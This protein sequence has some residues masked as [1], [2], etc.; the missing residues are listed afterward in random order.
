MSK[1][2]IMIWALVL[3]AVVF[4]ASLF[5]L[6]P[7]PEERL[8]LAVWAGNTVKVKALLEK[9]LDREYGKYR[10]AFRQ[11]LLYRSPGIVQAFVDAESENREEWVLLKAADAGRPE[12]VRLLIEAGWGINGANEKGETPLFIAASHISSQHGETVRF[13]VERGADVNA[14]TEYGCTPYTAFMGALDFTEQYDSETITEEDKKE[15]EEIK[16]LLQRE[17]DRFLFEAIEKRSVQ[18]AAQ[19]LDRGASLNTRDEHGNPPLV[20]AALHRDEPMIRFLTARGADTDP[21]KL[22]Q[23]KVTPLRA[24]FMGNIRGEGILS[25]VR[26]LVENGADI[27]RRGPLGESLLEPAVVHDFISEME[28]LI[29]RGLDV[30]S[31]N[32]HGKT[33]L[34]TA[35]LIGNVK[36]LEQLIRSGAVMDPKDYAGRN[37]L[38]YAVEF[39]QREA[40]RALLAS[41]GDV[42]TAIEGENDF[43]AGQT[44]LMYTAAYG[45]S[46]N[47]ELEKCHFLAGKTR[48]RH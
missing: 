32:E 29:G 21:K 9:G 27:N 3:A 20:R 41:G 43:R 5:F 25:M 8:L 36:A 44:L 46:L 15:F 18:R 37:A 48:S 4:I 40:L 19:A 10:E 16:R 33:P 23:S 1:V 6:L 12:I 13:L 31:P 47:D 35:A 30:N 45:V 11:A 34:M 7:G 39:G 28:Y 42:N 17:P 26:F 38:F 14:V 22:T 24:L 2:K